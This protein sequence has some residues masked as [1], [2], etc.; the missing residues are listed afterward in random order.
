LFQSKYISFLRILILCIACIPG[1]GYHCSASA[2]PPVAIAAVGEDAIGADA[3]ADFVKG[4]VHEVFND[5]AA[6]LRSRN[7][8][9]TQDAGQ[10]PAIAP[11]LLRVIYILWMPAE[12]TPVPSGYNPYFSPSAIGYY[13]FLFRLTPF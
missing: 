8:N 1:V 11:S 6:Y 3:D 2:I 12:H 13:R 9:N 7:N 10:L 5:E 4:D